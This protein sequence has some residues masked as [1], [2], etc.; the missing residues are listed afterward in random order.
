ML[1]KSEVGQK[2]S[3]QMTSPK[4]LSACCF[5]S[6][7]GAKPRHNFQLAHP[8]R[9]FLLLPPNLQIS[10]SK[11]IES[12]IANKPV[13]K[14]LKSKRIS[15]TRHLDEITT[16]PPDDY[17]DRDD[18]IRPA[19]DDTRHPDPR[20]PVLNSESSKDKVIGIEE[21][22]SSVVGEISGSRVK[23]EQDSAD[24]LGGKENLQIGELSEK[25]VE[26]EI[27]KALSMSDPMDLESNRQ[28]P[29]TSFAQT[30]RSSGNRVASTA[31]NYMSRLAG[32]SSA[33]P[34]VARVMLVWRTRGAR[35]AGTS[36]TRPASGVSPWS[37]ADV[38]P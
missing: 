22:F 34:D 18:E 36:G 21:K 19:D 2:S 23:L 3:K 30:S 8:H 29:E 28:C 32:T 1:G 37:S 31:R 16:H 11:P 6:T 38:I 24:M 7:N 17:T 14:K 27:V 26:G 13:R 33:K 20:H 5:P 25:E 35:Q 10:N 12:H 4:K 9:R 15:R